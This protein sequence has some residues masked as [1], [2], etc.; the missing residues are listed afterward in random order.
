VNLASSSTGTPKFAASSA[1]PTITSISIPAG[2]STANFF[3]GDTHAGAPIITVS[4]TGVTSGT[5]LETIMGAAPS[6]LVF[7][8]CSANG[9][10]AGSCATVSVG[11]SG[12]MDGFVSVVDAF[13]NVATVS[14]SSTWSITIT[15]SNGQFVVTNSPVT[16]TGP[17]TQS[18]T[19]FHV[20]NTGNNGSATLTAHATSGSPGVSD[21]TMTIQK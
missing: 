20:V 11:K 1:G 3:Y 16:I 10:A 19:R 9:G 7:T 15:S 8:N 12:F 6:K 17:A 14:A 5:Q 4:A 13:G 21:A 18:S 2:S